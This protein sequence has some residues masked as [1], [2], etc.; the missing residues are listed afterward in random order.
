[1][2][3]KPEK[4]RNSDSSSNSSSHNDEEQL[5]YPKSVFF[6]LSTEACERFSYYGMRAI[7][8]LYLKHLFKTQSNMG[9]AQAENLSTILYHAFVFLSYFTSLFGAFLADSFLG[10]FRTIFYISILYAVGQLI[11]SLGA[12]PNEAWNLPQLPLSYVGLILIGFGTGGIKPCVVSFG[13]DQFVLPQQKVEMASFFGIFYASINF[14][15]MIST[16]LTPIFRQQPCF[17]SDECFSLAFV[18]PAGLMVA[19]IVFFV[20]GRPGYKVLIPELNVVVDFFKCITEAI[21]QKRRA[22]IK[23]DHWL[24]YAEDR[25]GTTFV[26]DVKAVLRVCILFLMYPV[27]WA[28]YDQQGSRWTFQATRMDG[29]IGGVVILPDQMQVINAVLILIFIPIFDKIIY[30]LFARCNMLKSPLQK[31][32]TG[33]CLLAVAFVI[34]G[35]VE[36]IL[37]KTYP[38]PPTSEFSRLAFHNGLP[39]NCLLQFDLQQVG[40]D[41]PIQFPKNISGGQTLALRNSEGEQLFPVAFQN[42]NEILNFTLNATAMTGEDSKEDCLFNGKTS[43]IEFSLESEFSKTLYIHPGTSDPNS[44]EIYDP[45]NSDHIAKS[46]SGSPYIRAFFVLTNETQVKEL[47]LGWG[48]IILGDLNDPTSKNTHVALRT[49]IIPT[50]TKGDYFLGDTD[51]DDEAKTQGDFKVCLVTT[52][53]KNGVDEDVLECLKRDHMRTYSIKEET[54]DNYHLSDD[55]DP[56]LFEF[57]YGGSFNLYFSMSVEDEGEIMVDI[58]ETT[59]PN[60]IHMLWLLPQ[61]IVLT[62][63][64][65]LFSITSLAFAFTQAPSSMKAVVQALFLQT[66]AIGNLLDIFVVA[67]LSGVFKSQAYEFFL[68][69]ALMLIDMAIL[70]WLATRYTYSD[71]TNVKELEEEGRDGDSDSNRS[72]KKS[73]ESDTEKN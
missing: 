13:A 51:L 73:A 43:R 67:L 18:V 66:N 61:Y 38:V 45:L 72:S 41:E 50:Q 47:V 65:V 16:I 11:L 23:R 57:K 49:P 68:F 20:L 25:F 10:K 58:E 27:F 46:S 7:L 64:E 19:A 62:A 17:G 3:D 55:E 14:G 42:P 63:G 53:T 48:E 6:I 60:S 32:V 5:K 22:T 36:L 4:R 1:M 15:S 59:P 44:I 21:R 29:S 26:S 2:E 35:V 71:Y 31:I 8:A 40:K 69:A 52:K 56:G 70:A 54:D 34:S 33:G 28:L 24:D 12:V 9:D 37:E 39:E 30:P